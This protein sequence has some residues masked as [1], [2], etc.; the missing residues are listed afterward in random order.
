MKH[1]HFLFGETCFRFTYCFLNQYSKELFDDGVGIYRRKEDFLKK[2]DV[3]CIFW[4]T[5]WGMSKINITVKNK[6]RISLVKLVVTII[7]VFLARREITFEAV[8]LSKGYSSEGRYFWH[9]LTPVKSYRY[10]RGVT[11][12]TLRYSSRILSYSAVIFC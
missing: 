5:Y 4:V 2:K 7:S 6:P 1:P 9:L 3:I 11:L 10:F 8:V 12:G